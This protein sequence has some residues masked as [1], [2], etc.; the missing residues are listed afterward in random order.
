MAKKIK[1][2]LGFT[3]MAIFLSVIASGQVKIT[4]KLADKAFHDFSFNEAIDLYTY[5]HDKDPENVHVIRRLADCYRNIGSTEKSEKWYK[6]LVDMN[7]AYPEDLFNY[8]MALKSN[9]KYD[10]SEEILTEY[11]ELRPED[12]R[13][14]LAQSI[15]DYITFLQ[16]DS[17]RY[18]VE[19]VSFNTKGSDWG[20]V[21]Y[22]NKIVYVSTGDPD[23]NRDIK[24]NWDQLPFLDIYYVNVDEY[25]N[26]SKPEIYAKDLMTSYHDG[27]AT[28]DLKDNRMYFN[29]NRTTKNT[30]SH[31]EANNLQ[32]YYADLENGKWV[33]KGGFKYNNKLYS[34]AHPSIDRNGDILYFSSD[35]PGGKGGND[36]W[37]C[38]KVNGDW[39]EP[40]NLEKI[41]TEGNEAF[42][43]IAPDGVL[44]FASDGRGGMGGLDI[45]MALP[46]RGVF[47]TVEN[48]GFPVN[49]S[50]DDF[51]LVLDKSGMKGY[52]SSNR[53]GGKG[54]DDI[55]KL[56]ILWI[57]VQI[58]GTIRDRINTFEIADAKVALVD[59]N[60]DT[61]NVA[62]TKDDGEFVFEAYKNR[63]YKLV[64]SKEDYVT[65]EKDVSTY[66]KLPN[67]KIEVEMF[68]EMNFDNM[69][70]PDQ[71]EPLSLEMDG[72]DQLQ[73]IQIEHINYGFDSDKILPEAAEILDK[74]IELV[75]QYPDLE[76]K[77]ESHTDSKGSNEYNLK[78]S[79]L[80]AKSAYNYLVAHGIPA[81]HIEYTGYGETQLLN[82]CKDGVECSEEEHAINRRSIIK[83]IRRGKYKTKRNSR[84]IFYF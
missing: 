25:G 3:I 49:T 45:Y 62:L 77:V 8:S 19:N 83:V 33:Y 56:D 38:R 54:Y 81:N 41:N 43:F 52:F 17:S 75:K 28:F 82:R 69:E 26:Y 46:D 1:I 72:K 79:K 70:E 51:A 20:P 59:E 36:I 48:M 42:P 73:I 84:S 12:G 40:V 66:N 4:I 80:R 7:E 39:G 32:I 11:S 60:S 35:R 65:T 71:L 74:V 5:A 6:V 14:N 13:V 37:W 15:L 50:H 22:K 53:P 61:I 2:F 21:L 58:K 30:K 29:S 23:E 68:I 16:R 57:P 67:E 64:V 18:V 24:Y 76:I 31:D 9:G 44:Y 63:N 27:P 55:Y 78:L 10:Q 47:S 34:Y